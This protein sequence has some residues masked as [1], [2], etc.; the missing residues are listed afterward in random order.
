MRSALAYPPSADRL[1]RSRHAA[2]VVVF[3]GAG[4]RR[5]ALHRESDTAAMPSRA[6]A[7]LRL[8]ELRSAISRTID[9]S[10]PE[11]VDEQADA[12]S[13]ARSRSVSG[14]AQ[15]RSD[16]A[17][18][19]HSSTIRGMSWRRSRSDGIS[20]GPGRT[21]HCRHDSSRQMYCTSRLARRRSTRAAK[22][23]GSRRRRTHSDPPAAAANAASTSA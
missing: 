7:W 4:K 3:G 6:A 9:F 23:S 16:T 19:M 8:S 5:R 13:H 17:S 20:I 22:W 15:A 18:S 1:W 11:K 21:S 2:L 14:E 10:S 12:I